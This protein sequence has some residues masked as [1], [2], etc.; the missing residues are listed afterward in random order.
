MEQ[1]KY[2]DETSFESNFERWF[3]LNCD[4]KKVYNEKPYKREEALTVFKNYV[5]DKWQED[6]KK[7]S[8]S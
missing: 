5:K 1:F 8:R 3:L 4:E 2:D 7:T 6:Q